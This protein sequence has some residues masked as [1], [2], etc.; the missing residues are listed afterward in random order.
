MLQ[1]D[2]SYMLFQINF[3]ERDLLDLKQNKKAINIS[4]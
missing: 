1:F 4:S 3:F 2:I